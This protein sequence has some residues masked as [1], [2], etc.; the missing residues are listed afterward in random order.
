MKKFYL[1][2]VISC[3]TLLSSLNALALRY[4]AA[5]VS[6][7]GTPATYCSNVTTGTT[8]TATATA[9]SGCT[10]GTTTTVVTYTWYDNATNSTSTATA[11]VRATGTVNFTSSGVAPAIPAYTPNPSTLGAGSH[12]IFCRLSWSVN[13]CVTAGSVTSASTV[14]ITVNAAP[15]I[16]GTLYNCTAGSTVSLTGSPSGG[17]WASSATGVATVSS[18]GDVG[19]ASSGA[20]TI[21]YTNGGCT[22]TAAFTNS[23]VPAAITGSSSLCG[24]L[25]LY[26]TFNSGL[27]GEV[28]GTWSIVNTAG[29]T[30]TYF[31]LLASPGYSSAVTG[32][33]SQYVEASPD[34]LNASTIT[35]VRSPSFSTLGLSSATLTFNHYYYYYSTGDVKASVDYSTDGG[36]TWTTIT[37]YKALAV[38]AGA[39]TWTVGTPNATLSL[40]AGALGQGSVMLRF[41]YS[42]VY[43]F[44]WAIDNVKLQSLATSSITLG[45]TVP[46]G[47]WSTSAAN[48]AS[49]STSGVVTGLGAGTANISYTTACGAVGQSISVLGVPA[50]IGG[51]ASVCVGSITTLTNTVTGGAWTSANSAIATVNSNGGVTGV[52]AGTVNITYSTGCGSAAVKTVTVN[53]LPSISGTMSVCNG[54][55]VT[56]TGS[57]TPGTWARTNGTGTISITSPGGVVTGSAAGTATVTYTYTTTGCAIAQ[58]F[59]VNPNPTV[60]IS[61]SNL[62]CS[63]SSGTTLTASGTGTS[64]AWSPSATLSSATGASVVANPSA[65]QIYTVVASLGSCTAT[66]TNSIAYHSVATMLDTTLGGGYVCLPGTTPYFAVTTLTPSTVY[67]TYGTYS[68]SDPSIATVDAA[69]GM[70]YG[71]GAGTATITYTDASCGYYVNQDI[72]VYNGGFTLS[73]SPSSASYCASAGPVTLT[74]VPAGGT[75]D[76]YLWTNADLSPATGLSSTNTIATNASPSA[77]QS[78]IVSATQSSSGC[79][80]QASVTVTNTTVAAITGGNTNIC[81]G[82]VTTMSDATSSGTWSSSNTAMASVNSATGAIT[83]G[84][85]SG[86]PYIS[87]SIGGGCYAVRQI[88]VNQ[89]P[90]ATVTPSSACTPAVLTA[91]SAATYSWTPATGLSATNTS[92]VT[93]TPTVAT[94]YTVTLANSAVCT[95]TAT[96]SVTPTPQPITGTASMCAP[97]SGIGSTTLLAQNFSSLTGSV[98][99]TW[100]I[101]NTSGNSSTYFA[102]RTSPGYSSAV[103][104][105][106]SQYMEASPDALNGLT[107]TEVRSPAFSTVGVPSATLTFNHYYY[108]YASG[109]VNANVDYSTDGGTSWTSII[110]YVS[111]GASAGATTWTAGTPNAT[112]ALPA[113]ALNQS[114]VMLR[115]YYQSTYGFYWAIDNVQLVGPGRNT[116]TLSESVATGSWSSSAPTIAS[117]NTSGIVT[118]LSAG[119]ANIS[120]TNTCGSAVKAVTVLGLPATIGGSLNVAVG[121]S[122]TLTNATLYGSWSTASSAIATINAATGQA[123]GVSNGTTGVTYTTGCGSAATAIITVSTPC[124]GTPAAGTA[125][126]SPASGGATTPFVASITGYDLSSGITF[127]WQKSTTSATSG[128]TNISG[129][130]NAT[131]NFTGITSNTWYQCVVTCGTTSLSAT[132]TVTAASYYA[133]S[134]CTPTWTY[135]SY[136]CTYNYALVAT[137]GYPFMLSGSSGSIYDNSACTSA[138]YEDMSSTGPTVTLKQGNNYTANFS[139]NIYGYSDNV[140][141]WIDFNNDGTFSASESVGGTASWTSTTLAQ[142][143]SIPGSPSVTTGTVRMRVENEYYYHNYPNLSPCPTTGST[144]YYGDVRDYKVNIQALPAITV[145]G[146]ATSLCGGSTVTFSNATTGGTWSSSN[147]ARVAINS[148]TGV[149]VGGT[150]SGIDTIYYSAS[151]MITYYTITNVAI[152]TAISGAS[153]VCVSQQVTLTEA[154][155]GGTWSSSSTANATVSSAGVVGG[156]AGGT[157]TISYSTGCGTP[158]TFP[159]TV[160]LL[161][162]TTTASATSMCSGA[163]A[164]LT[165]TVPGGT[166]SSSDVSIASVNSTS[167]VVTGTG[168]GTVTITYSMGCATYATTAMS[169]NVA[170]ADINPLT[171]VDLCVGLT[172]TLTNSSLGGSWSS[173][174][175]GIA[176]VNSTTGVVG[177]VA[178]GT[179]T[180]TY[181]NACGAPAT[182]DVNVN[183]PPNA[184]ISGTSTVCQYASTTLSNS[185]A[186]GAWYSAN[187]SIATVDATTGEMGGVAG[188]TV[189]ISYVT[190]GCNPVTSSFTVTP[191]PA[192]ISGTTVACTSSSATLTNSVSGGT[193]SSSNT[194]VANINASTG[195]LTSTA[196]TGIT[197]ISYSNGCAPAATVVFTVSSTPAAIGGTMS[198]CKP[199]TPT[200]LTSR[201]NGANPLTDNI[202]GTDWTIQYL[203]TAASSFGFAAFN[204]GAFGG[205]T[206]NGTKFL[207]ANAD[208][209]GSGTTLNSIATSPSFS[210]IGLSAA[211]LTFNTYMFSSSTWDAASVLEYSSNGGATWTVLYDY[212]GATTGSST[213]TAGSPNQT[214]ALPASMLGVPNALIRFRYQ[215]SWGFYWGID[216]VVITGAPTTSTATLTNATPGGTW[217]S[218][219]TSVATIV[220][221]T[222]AWT[223]VAPGTSTITYASPCGSVTATVT[224]NDVPAAIS[225]ASTVCQGASISLTNSVSGGT[226]SSYNSGIATVSATGVVTG[227]A[228]GSTY[229]LYSNGCGATAVKAVTVT[230]LPGSIT[231]ATSLCPG[232]AGTLFN[233]ASG[234]TWSTSNSAIVS[235]NAATGYATAVGASGTSATITYTTGCAPAATAVVSINTTAAI[236]GTTSACASLGSASTILA[237]NFNT[238]LTGTT[239]GTWSIL[240]TTGNAA[241]LFQLRAA[242]GYTS[243]VPGDGSQYMQANPGAYFTTTVVTEFRSPAFSTIGMTAGTIAYSQYYSGYSASDQVKVDYSLDGG[244]TWTNISTLGGAVAGATTWTTS[245]PNTSLS[246]PAG[247]RN[248]S[249]VMLR[250]YLSGVAGGCNWAVDN[251]NVSGVF[252]PYT[253]LSDATPGGSWSSSAPAVASITSTG[254]VFGLTAGTATISYAAACGTVTTNFTVNP[255]P[256]AIIGA[257]YVCVGSTT[258]MGNSLSG[259]TW[260]VSDATIATINASTGVVTGIA[261]GTVQVSYSTTCGSPTPYTLTVRALPTAI[262]GSTDLCPSSVGTL[263]NTASGGTWSISSTTSASV[264]AS[265]GVITATATSGTATVTYS[266]GCGTGQYATINVSNATAPIAGTTSACTQ[267]AATTLFTQDWETPAGSAVPTGT[268]A[269]NG[270]SQ[271]TNPSVNYL[272][273]YTSGSSPAASPQSGSYFL[274]AYCYYYYG[275]QTV[276][277]PSFSLSGTNGATMTFWVYR[278]A[279]SSYNN[280]TYGGEGF[281]VRINTTPALTGAT[282]LGFVPRA[283]AVSTSGSY[284]SGTATTSTAGWYQYRVTTPAGFTGSTNYIMITA[285]LGT[286]TTSSFT[287]AYLDNIKLT[288]NPFTATLTDATPGG[289]W[290][291]S[292][293]AI[294][295]VNVT[296]G[297]VSAISTGTA[298]ITYTSACGTPVTATFTVNG[299]PASI[300][301]AG[302]VCIGSNLTL[303]NTA[304]N[305]T[306]S[307]SN[308]TVATINATTGVLTGLTAGTATV[309]YANGCGTATTATVTVKSAPAAISGATSMCPSTTTNLTNSVSGGTWSSSDPSIA[310]IGTFSG[311]VYATATPGTTTITYSNTCSP[312]VT[313]VI[314]VSSS[315]DTIVGISAICAQ[316]TPLVS[317][318]FESGVPSVQG[319]AVAGWNYLQGTGA[320]NNYWS[321]IAGTSTASPA[322][323][324]TP[325]GG[326]SFV[327]RFGSNTIT[328]G[329]TAYLVSPAFDLG[330]GNGGR[331]T[332]Y[333]YRDGNLTSNYDSLAVY[334]NTSASASGATR[335]GSV[336]R[337][338]TLSTAYVGTAV[339][340]GWQKL[341]FT[342]PTTFSGSTNYILFKGYSAAGNNMYLDSVQIRNNSGSATFT[343]AT[344][345]GTWSTSNASVATV[346]TGGVVSAVGAGTATISYTGACGAPVTKDVTVNAVPGSNTIGATTLCIGATTT[347]ANALAGGTWYSS[348]PT[349]ATVDVSGTVTALSAGTATISYFN[350][351][352]AAATTAVTVNAVP[353]IAAVSASASSLCAGSVL[354]L[355]AGSVTGAGTLA[356][357]NWSGPDSYSVTGTAT[358]NARLVNNAAASGVYSVTVTYPGLGCTSTP[359]TVAATV[360]DYPVAQTVTGGNGCSATGITVGLSGTQSGI[361]YVLVQA[362][363][364]TV[365]TLAGTGA[366][367]SFTP[368]TATGTYIVNATTGPGCATTMTGADTIRLTPTITPGLMPSICQGITDQSI[369]YTPT[370]GAPATYSIDWNAAANTAGFTDITNAPLG[371]TLGYSI[372]ATGAVGLFTGTITVSNG[373]CVSAGYTT[374]LTVYATPTMTMTDTVI[375]CYGYA[376][377]IV[378]SG[379]DSTTVN[380]RVNGGALNHFT[381]SG[382]TYS[383]GTGVLTTPVTYQI[384]SASNPVCATTYNDTVTITPTPMMWVGGTPGFETDW[385]TASNWSCGFVPTATDS[386]TIPGTL[387]AP[388]MPAAVSA[389]VSDLDVASGTVINLNA[390]SALHVAGNVHSSGT[391]A[392]NG[393]VILSGSSA[394]KIYGIGTFSNVELN[395][396][397]GATIQ[398]GARMMISKAVYLTAGTLTTNDSLELLSTDTFAAA[399]I[400]EIPFGAGVSGKVKTDQYVQGGYRRFRFWGHSFSDTISLSQLT[401]YIDITGPGGSSNGFTTTASNNPSAFRYDPDYGDDTSSYSSGWRPFTRINSSAADSNKLHPGQ[402]IRLFFRGSKGEGL[403]YLGYFGMYTPSATINKMNGHVNQGPVSIYLRQG[404]VAPLYQSYNQISNPY[405]SPVDIGTVLFNAK[406]AGQVTGAAFYVWNPSIGAGGQYMAIPIGTTSAQPY[407]IQ[408]N[409]SFQ[410]KANYD[411]AHVDFTEANKV[412]AASLNLFRAPEQAVRFNIYDTSYHLWDV[413]SMQFN[414]KASDA[415]DK[416]LDATKPDGPDMNFYS[417]AAD[418]RKLAID[419]RPYEGDKVIP[420]GVKSAYRQDFLIRAESIS[421]PTGGVVTLHD[422]LLNKY[423]D[424]KEG[425]EYRF[426]IGKD[427]ATQGDDRFELVLK[428][429]TA[430]AVKGLEVSMAPNPASDDVKI[431]FTSGS[432]DNVS[433]RIMDVSGVSIYNQ[434]LG[435]KQNGVITVP[436][437]N[438]AAGVYMVEITQGEQKV[439][440]R[441]VKE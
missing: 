399:R 147:S 83:G 6:I 350:G 305:G 69:Y 316:P 269:V 199:A 244:T 311:T 373:Y 437:S 314:T 18:S 8:I 157:V 91:A 181:S 322:T 23:S 337:S 204:S 92:S 326:G 77:T 300:V 152:P 241:S 156:V 236:A 113:G 419:A 124:T 431:T 59:T 441:L 358:T 24:S 402:G 151:G 266:N 110:N 99:G 169:I 9:T 357:Y 225:G 43:G 261:A 191:V 347:V 164:T 375:P 289:T 104:G 245:S 343:D 335:I 336:C 64:Y 395:N 153:T 248:Q 382:T 167:G 271:L 32:D 22:A 302:T 195:V 67:A 332:M 111:A 60:S 209:A 317:T 63:N 158:A 285:N 287:Y 214:F 79:H 385:N 76:V 149:A 352:G 424:M 188:G 321:S 429:T 162:G 66:A 427:K 370:T 412:A 242:P 359:A 222:G 81:N 26:A 334:I 251:I 160:N 88:T 231:G 150:E 138:G 426:T 41:Y 193:W 340:A 320:A 172:T 44:Y 86:T 146:S 307:I 80:A 356:S 35:E 279:T 112:L 403:G 392:G 219:T 13:G 20:A 62:Y 103:T 207:G 5:S 48:I 283:A 274:A 381:F 333:F 182:R 185:V 254:T 440:K 116:V 276:V 294:A 372:P 56:L 133:P 258:T 190:T 107:V 227:V 365:Q 11:T 434:D 187:T 324:G 436:M 136:G 329:N 433:V 349:V 275:D 380:Y 177:G 40:P 174:N 346:T 308:P 315:T 102:L 270:W 211:T 369:A 126:I 338:R 68:T 280:S 202:T 417:I 108:Y 37:D 135:P 330:G 246:I 229:I 312:D 439:T 75:P 123:F 144:Y 128:F 84:T 400:A 184:T 303:T 27:A 286:G 407:Y 1:F 16:S 288:V 361:T 355:T 341:T 196:T 263:Y 213:W 215:S 388:V 416:L 73:V 179:A 313:S 165:N 257:S 234:G 387:Y 71:V 186:G 384:V 397:N 408:A 389:T 74:A 159:M 282:T 278:D 208:G 101:L 49:V 272:Y 170:P 256:G 296:S 105:D 323:S 391:V 377:S 95:V 243:A 50:S 82:T 58:S 7:A 362:P 328:S 249:S 78:Y 259:G 218:G 354:T 180:I 120:Y 360:Y 145:T 404:S 232:G 267:V 421:V 130:T 378:F 414:D 51:T 420:L 260:S 230:A 90:S 410:V 194:S 12:Y 344:S 432:K 142:P 298:T 318:S 85:T 220:G 173:S 284:I 250:W 129:A 252:N 141:I 175:T 118:G 351:C 363:S 292:N 367:M 183:T 57:P 154:V 304:T 203:G 390:G 70:V 306:W 97:I 383:L 14:L 100:S 47:T 210:T 198:L 55:Q 406:Q 45:E 268:T 132:S 247:A 125:S 418:G 277:S 319:T 189:T 223:S 422:K 265:T 114:S 228:G 166:W 438:F 46:N 171:T 121:S 134:S 163:T 42:S 299:N 61:S 17:T 240:N 106:G 155:T 216:D 293:S 25:L 201:F 368:V 131:Y 127:Q 290:S 327:A 423:V 295:S 374:T 411:G 139:A 430:T 238:G 98:G 65:S 224:V 52:S 221:G 379:P 273:T 339:A 253:V 301:G 161:P 281:T 297:V 109:D 115:F 137:T 394:Q 30:S 200:L 398:P 415:E 140:Q 371:S 342:I 264:N 38:S 401:P 15:T 94:N 4:T 239:G 39:T 291:S 148:S 405:P 310:T 119:V 31:R 396:S 34:A 93:A 425:T 176:T 178:T 206:G 87:Y 2:V 21:S 226:W 386:V 348:A 96:A 54:K 192:A 364:A 117:V 331:V 345:G 393:R 428:P 255:A 10:T 72:R 28:G 413:L 235:V 36:S 197:T 233:T 409:T 53:A 89:Y 435:T 205:I 237:Q 168:G 325:S 376:G 353:T 262:T 3:L 217:S 212:Y 122:A 309:T 143:I 33:G 29:N 366:A 19:Y